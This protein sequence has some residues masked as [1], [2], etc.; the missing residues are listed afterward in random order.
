MKRIIGFVAMLF[1]CLGVVLSAVAIAGCWV[2]T[3]RVIEQ[4][5]RTATAVD[6]GLTT[7]D[8]A[9]GR[10]ADKLDR[11]RTAA[12]EVRA[13]AER[14]GDKQEIVQAEVAA[15]FDRLTP[16][17]ERADGLAESL[18]AVAK[19][20]NQSADLAERFGGSGETSRRM[21]AA[22]D[23]LASVCDK[24]GSIRDE[25]DTLRAGKLPL[26]GERVHK[27]ADLA[28]EHISRLTDRV[29]D[30]RQLVGGGRSDV[31]EIAAEVRFWTTVAA[32]VGTALAVWGG[33]AQLCLIGWGRRRLS[34][35]TSP[36]AV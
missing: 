15:V 26:S 18:R 29:S 8:E 11:T 10:I 33:L 2:V 12:G 14:W 24:L 28:D 3:S 1:G 21:R 23:S 20:L 35:P 22:A 25:V 9:L 16:V 7:T 27:L 17:V 32:V 5:E 19:L 31:K 34:S 36:A 4:T 30:V 13:A 6:N